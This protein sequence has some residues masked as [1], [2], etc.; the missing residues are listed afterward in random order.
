MQVT[1]AQQRVLRQIAER[2]V[3]QHQVDTGTAP[4]AFPQNTLLAL[5]TR[6]LILCEISDKFSRAVVSLTDMGR[7]ML[8]A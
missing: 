4:G 1:P 8:D 2:G 7:S 6:G 3:G 5:K